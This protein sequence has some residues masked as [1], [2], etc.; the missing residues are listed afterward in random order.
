MRKALAA[1]EAPQVARRLAPDLNRRAGDEA[2]DRHRPFLQMIRAA[3]AT[4]AM[5]NSASAGS[6]MSRHATVP[7]TPG[8]LGHPGG[9]LEA[10][11]GRQR[12]PGRGGG[13]KR[14]RPAG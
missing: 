7:R 4:R 5:K 14:S 1:L 2:D 9:P 13:Y 8:P 11:G 10:R 12:R 3:H 6:P